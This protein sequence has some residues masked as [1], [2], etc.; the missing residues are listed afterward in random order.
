MFHRVCS[1]SRMR[2]FVLITWHT[3]CLSLQ[4]AVMIGG[5]FLYNH[6]GE[7]L[8]SRVFRDSVTWGNMYFTCVI[9]IMW[10]GG[11]LVISAL[12]FL[13]KQNGRVTTEVFFSDCHRSTGY[14]ITYQSH[15]VNV[16]INGVATPR[17]SITSHT[18]LLHSSPVFSFSHYPTSGIN[19]LCHDSAA[20]S[21]Y[22]VG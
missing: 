1:Q 14:F 2:A 4:H 13:N 20:C 6:K 22:F 3:G 7:V 19:Q 15:T 12:V 5:V 18:C 16:V 10:K 11:F 9:Y 17:F 21:I 8:I